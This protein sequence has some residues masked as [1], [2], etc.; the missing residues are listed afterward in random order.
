MKYLL[1]TIGFILLIAILLVVGFAV[2]WGLAWLITFLIASFGGTL[3]VNWWQ[4]WIITIILGVVR[5]VLTPR[6]QNAS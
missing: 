3:V 4:V 1:L 6:Q 2:H 5:N